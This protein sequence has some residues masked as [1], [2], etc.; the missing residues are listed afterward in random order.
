MGPIRQY[1]YS[2][3]DPYQVLAHYIVGFYRPV[4][5]VRCLGDNAYLKTLIIKEMRGQDF[6]GHFL[7]CIIEDILERRERMELM[8]RLDELAIW[9]YNQLDKERLRQE[10]LAILKEAGIDIE[11]YSTAGNV[12]SAKQ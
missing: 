11:L 9:F 10:I 12:S 4:D 1:L 2:A 6:G 5:V 8:H 7:D 3:D